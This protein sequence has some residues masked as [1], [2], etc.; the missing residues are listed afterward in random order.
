AEK[1]SHEMIH[2]TTSNSLEDIKQIPLDSSVIVSVQSDQSA[3]PPRRFT[4]CSSS[5][6]S[7]FCDDCPPTDRGAVSHQPVTLELRQAARP[8]QSEA[9]PPPEGLGAPDP[10]HALQLEGL[11]P[12]TAAGSLQQ[13]GATAQSPQQGATQ[14]SSVPESDSERPPKVD[15]AD[16]RIKTLDE[17]LRTLLYQEHGG[18]PGAT[19]TTREQAVAPGTESPRSVSSSETTVAGTTGEPHPD[20]IAAVDPT[21]PLPQPAPVE[22]AASTEQVTHC[23]P[24]EPALLP[25]VSTEAIKEA[26]ATLV[27]CLSTDPVEKQPLQQLEKSI[28]EPSDTGT[29]VLQPQ[30]GIAQHQ[31]GAGDSRST[32]AGVDP[33]QLDQ[34]SSFSVFPDSQSPMQLQAGRFQVS[35]ATLHPEGA[36]PPAELESCAALNLLTADTKEGMAPG[37]QEPAPQEVAGHFLAGGTWDS[38]SDTMDGPLPLPP[39]WYDD[40]VLPEVASA[41]ELE[42]RPMGTS[43]NLQS[44]NSQWLKDIRR[45]GA[46][47]KQPS[48]ES[49]LSVPVSH[50]DETGEWMC[51]GSRLVLEEGQWPHQHNMM[52]CNSPTSPMSSDDESDVE[53][54][55]L[56]R[57]L[58]SLREKH[59]KEVVYLQAQ[60]NQ[61]LQ[62]LY[63]RLRMPRDLCDGSLQAYSPPSR[64][65]RSAKSKLR[66][67]KSHSLSS[68]PTSTGSFYCTDSQQTAGTKKGTFTDDLH[69]LVDDWAK[70]RIGVA[71]LKPSLNEIRQIQTRQD[72]ESWHQL[73]D[74]A[75]QTCT[76]GWIGSGSQGQGTQQTT[77]PPAIPPSNSFP[78]T[79][80]PYPLQNLC[81]YA[82]IA[83]GTYQSQ[84]S[85]STPSQ[86]LPQH[87]AGGGGG[88]AGAVQTFPLQGSPTA[89]PWSK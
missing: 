45:G 14:P 29:Q 80:A 54:E 1:L 13:L 76:V 33:S 21:T 67:A 50:T 75:S 7:S 51:P 53:D 88:G 87:L 69:K 60:Q 36:I 24:H 65:Q 9:D 22:P 74:G 63:E 78:G 77:L 89:P 11:V 46:V 38:G 26:D 37:P 58:Q 47:C 41:C 59:I 81:Q 82:G 4:S 8:P 20:S 56:K 57:E 42:D 86:G 61:E 32:R 30:G 19:E 83:R 73:C 68:T 27:A 49:E 55:D 3:T 28:S 71:S 39:S 48:T 79:V 85:G 62:E 18:L 52:L 44:A 72:L 23:S 31:T 12:A 17:K 34:G 16:N 84:P 40:E 6:S 70:E 35:A 10:S 66:S 5:S 25:S 64:R 15:F 2:L 43:G